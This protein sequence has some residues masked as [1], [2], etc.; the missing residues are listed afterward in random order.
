MTRGRSEPA[1]FLDFLF[2]FFDVTLFVPPLA[3]R[4]SR[5]GGRLVGFLL[6]FENCRFSREAG[7]GLGFWA[8]SLHSNG[9][10]LDVLLE[11][12]F[13][14]LGRRSVL[15]RGFGLLGEKWLG[16][17]AGRIHEKGKAENEDDRHAPHCTGFLISHNGL[18]TG[19]TDIGIVNVPADTNRAKGGRP[20]MNELIVALDARLAGTKNT[21]DTSYWQGLIWGLGQVAPEEKI[22]LIGNSPRPDSLADCPFRWVE[23]PASNRRVWSIWALPRAA[24]EIGA[25]VLHTQ[26]NVSPLTHCR[27]VTTIHD[28]S[29]FVNPS[30]YGWK[31]RLVLTKGIPATC[32]RADQILAVSE[33]TKR[34]IEQFIPAARGKVNVT[35]NALSPRFHPPQKQEA[36]RQVQREF[37]IE[38]PFVFAITS[39]WARKNSSLAAKAFSLS[40]LSRTHRLVTCG[41]G[42]PLN[43][44]SFHLG[45][46]SESSIMALYA[47]ADCFVLPSLHEGFGIPILEAYTSGT[48]VI[49]GSG[50]AIPEVA[51]DAATVCS[52]YRPETWASAMD[53]LLGD[54]GKLDAMIARGRERAAEFSWI[55]TAE[56]TWDAYQRAASHG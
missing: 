18:V 44:D 31:D 16:Q 46:V 23:V 11:H 35:P 17:P 33:T 29:F 45:Y 15:G 53:G 51:G 4:G 14:L 25:H 32:R 48:P 34:E 1:F 36:T 13:G 39:R 28:V 6:L 42:E 54:S 19:L 24:K 41:P 38:G 2:L 50:G 30:W 22:V 55:T 47:A 52:D 20:V 43:A 7:V 10:L 3:G 27:S 26:Y 12:F 49:C 9:V 21:G 37:G 40:H 8:L 5:V 56:L